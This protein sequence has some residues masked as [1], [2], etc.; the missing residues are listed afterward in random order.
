MKPRRL[1]PTLREVASY[2]PV[3]SLTGP[4]QSGKSTL[5]RGAF[6]DLPRRSL[7]APDIRLYAREDPRGFLAELRAGAIIDEVQHAPELLSYLQEEVDRDPTPGRF[8]LTGSEHLSV[9][10]RVAQSLAGRAG[11]LH[12][13]PL[14]WDELGGFGAAHRD[15]FATMW[16][17]GY[18]RIHDVGIPPPRWLGDYT[19]NY[20][21]RDV[22]QLLNITDLDTFTAFLK[23]CAGATGQEINLSRLGADAGITANTAKAWLSVLEASFICFRL[24]A[25]TPNIRKQVVKAPKLHFFDSGLACH[26]LGIR[27]S[28]ELRHHPLRGALFESWVASEVY[29]HRVHR[30]ERPDLWHHR[31]SRSVEVDIIDRLA[32]VAVEVKSGATIV[33]ETAANLA[34]SLAKLPESL[35]GRIVYGGD[36]SRTMHGVDLCAW[37]DLADRYTSGA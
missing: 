20:V 4:R 17:G 34:E 5:T 12:L 6:P 30:G 11:V 18:P 10:S 23:L 29:K 2:Y 25:W 26:L 13:L 33:P 27:T 16:A 14:S 35:A 1:E 31:Q 3:V 7:E 8:I 36:E 19:A 37:R 9:S 28:A 21:Q 22:R 24:P 32:G 15:L